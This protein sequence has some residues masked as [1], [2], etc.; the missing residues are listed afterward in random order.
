MCLGR[1]SSCVPSAKSCSC[2]LMFVQ[3][4]QMGSVISSAM[5]IDWYELGFAA[6]L[7]WLSNK[8]L[9]LS[10]AFGLCVCFHVCVY[11]HVCFYSYE[12]ALHEKKLPLEVICSCSCT[13]GFDMLKIVC[14]S[15][16]KCSQG[17]RLRGFGVLFLWWMCIS[18]SVVHNCC[19]YSVRVKV[20]FLVNL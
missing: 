10:V 18:L 14:C 3:I 1:L 12:A 11:V 15:D 9:S 5:L 20:C 4:W 7:K 17:I 19:D 2:A 16:L 6:D 13:C 8:D